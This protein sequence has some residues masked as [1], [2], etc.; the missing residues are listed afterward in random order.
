MKNAAALYRV[1]WLLAFALSTA[2]AEELVRPMRVPTDVRA[3]YNNVPVTAL[4][5][6]CESVRLALG[7]AW[8]DA[9]ACRA[10][11]GYLQPWAN[12]DTQRDAEA[13][14]ARGARMYELVKCVDDGI[15]SV[16][17]ARDTRDEPRLPDDVTF[18]RNELALA[19]KQVIDYADNAAALKARLENQLTRQ[20]ARRN[21]A[22]KQ[23]DGKPWDDPQREAWR[24]AGPA[25]GVRLPL[26]PRPGS[27]PE[28]WDTNLSLEPGYLAT[29]L[30]SAGN[31]FFTP[32]YPVAAWGDNCT[33]PGRYDW[34]K[35]DKIVRMLKDRRCR[36]LLE[37]PTLQEAR[38]DEQIAELFE[39]ANKRAWY[40]IWHTV[41]VRSLPKH[42]SDSATAS[43]AARN[44][45]GSLRPHG[46]V[47]LFDATTAAAYGEYLKA[48][49]AHLKQQGLYDTVAAIHL[50][51]ADWAELPESVDYSDFTK[52]RWQKFLA[53][54]YGNVAAL[55]KNAGTNYQSF[56]RAPIPFRTV[57][58]RAANDWAEFT[59]KTKEVNANAW[60]RFTQDKYKSKEG[61]R[62]TLGDDYQDGYSWRLPMIYP[63]VIGIDYL[64]F[65]RAWVKEY[66]AVKR[67]LVQAA[68][69]DKLV[70]TEMRQ[71]GDHDGVQGLG[72][73][74][75]GGFLTD[76][77]GQWTGTG[78]ENTTRPFMIR[79]VGPPGFG[80][81]PS[82][83]IESLYRDYLF[84]NFRDPGNLTRYFYHW[85][86]HGYMDYQLGW[87]SV[88][89]HWLT[90]RLVYAVGP[91]VANTAPQPQRIGLLLPRETFDLNDGRVYFGHTGWDWVLNAAKLAY[92]RI[93]EHFVRDG[94]LPG[95]GLELLIL[96]DG[97]N[98]SGRAAMDDKLAAE[99]ARWVESG[100]T[101]IASTIPGLT[102]EYGRPRPEPALS[103]VLGVL[104]GG[105]T[106]EPVKGTPLTITVPHGHYSGKWQKT[107]DRKPAFQ[108]LRPTTAKVLATYDSGKP[109]IAENAHGKGR[110][111]TLGYPFGTEAV[112]CEKTSIGFQRTYVWFVREPQ[113][114]ARTKWIREFI[115]KQL[116]YKPDYG[117]DYAEVQRFKGVEEIA[118]GFHMP[119]GLV[120]DAND[121]FFIQTMGDPRPGHQMPVSR[122]ETDVAIRFFPRQRDGVSTKYLGISTREVHYLGPRATIEMI[123]A[124]HSYRCRINNPKIMAI[125]DV[126][127]NVPVGF[128]RDDRGVSF[129]VS[130]PSGHIMMLAVS[131]T[132]V[133]ELFEPAAF[134]GRGKEDVLARCKELAGGKKPPAVVVLTPDIFS[135]LDE[136]RSPPDPKQPE[137]KE[138]LVISCGQPENRKAAETLAKFLREKLGVDAT[139]V[140]QAVKM[141]ANYT[142]RLG[143]EWQ[144]PVILIGD[145]WTNNDMGMHGAYWGVAYGAHLPFTATYAWPGEGRA[146]VSLSRRYVLTDDTGRI[147]FQADLSL[148]LRPAERRFTLLRRKL[149]I[150]AN[151]KDAE[152]AVNEIIALL[153][154]QSRR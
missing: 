148:R 89:N 113:L 114:V 72:E 146:V 56:D 66:L 85:V 103:K 69:P 135:W 40:Q 49:A 99:I 147:P 94:K 104:P 84:L 90:N 26:T 46:G 15:N 34:A 95:L 77:H 106:S 1:T 145:E 20:A 8:D 70:I 140:E 14:V 112:A 16:R 17:L 131:E 28:W 124:R 108:V 151:G 149:H 91:T 138:T 48:M 71:F 43:L 144:T 21:I 100:G 141:P 7:A 153:E 82:D 52:A 126:V 53:A 42:L 33:G 88:T 12:A 110:A 10:L 27:L 130:L 39:Q 36:F 35:L 22:A 64:H 111:V 109:A 154:K 134:P 32:E 2:S 96:P 76:D 30:H 120:Q 97:G 68:F 67:S 92:T 123:L 81:R 102:D 41:P 132:P 78:P 63:P 83:S 107:T 116:G 136:L 118:P 74:K 47:Q 125:W 23:I 87:H 133:V 18:W 105:T 54:R 121:P 122:E 86:G 51:A 11:G 19:A 4:V 137:K 61:V 24:K 37:L 93:D 62:K 13:V 143:N 75:W 142:D 50:E 65:R 3:E 101:L 115:E 150:A 45:D 129:T 152:R 59:Q 73:K 5:E 9:L 98:R 58:P 6:D 55:N 139:T 60:A 44:D 128:K 29:K 57:D 38:T 25:T 119:K 117:V 127:R 79:S 31:S 80:T